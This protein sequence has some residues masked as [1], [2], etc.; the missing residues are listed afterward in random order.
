MPF[1]KRGLAVAILTASVTTL[2]ANPAEGEHSA[3]GGGGGAQLRAQSPKIG[4]D[5][6]FKVYHAKTGR[7]SLVK[8]VEAALGDPSV[9]QALADLKEAFA[10]D[11]LMEMR[12]SASIVAFAEHFPDWI[13]AAAAKQ[14]K[15][16]EA[17]FA[18]AAGSP[19][20]IANKLSKTPW[21]D[22]VLAEFAAELHQSTKAPGLNAAVSTALNEITFKDLPGNPFAPVQEPWNLSAIISRID[23]HGEA[24]AQVRRLS[25]R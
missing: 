24:A 13:R 21:Q 8:A 16:A 20:L 2:Q 4:P 17:I 19:F 7:P 25:G 9:V 22:E 14:D 11:T 10:G 5:T 15:G 18:R 23:A 6:F 12:D 3:A 1:K